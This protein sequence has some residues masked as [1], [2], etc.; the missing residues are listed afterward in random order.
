[1]KNTMKAVVLEST[2][3][4]ENFLYKDAPLPELK[5]PQHVLVRVQACGVAYRDIIERRG[6]HPLLRTPIIQGHEFSGEVVSVGS[7][8]KRWKL[9]DRVI[10]RYTDSCGQCDECVGGDERLCIKLTQM[11]GLITDG[12]YAEQVLMHERGLERLHDDIDFAQG[13]C[14]MSAV[15]VAYHNVR[16]RLAVRPGETVLLTGASGGVGLAALQCLKLLGATVWAVTSS[17][18]KVAFLEEM[19]ADRVLVND[20]KTIHKAVRAIQPQG[21][22][23]AVDCV[24]SA[25]LGSVLKSMRRLGR[26]AVVGT[27][28][29]EPLSLNLGT[30]VVNGLTIKG[31][32]GNTRQAIRESMALVAAGKI[33]V[34]IDRALPLSQ[35]AEAHRMLENREAVGRILLLPQANNEEAR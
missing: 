10:N 22:D 24:G 34:H 21:I 15:A 27:I 33:R 20:G 26:V 29:P 7:S 19:G 16:N 11:Y 1:M 18:D 8:V 30:L 6:G 2:G 4:A 25:T 5:D 35:A 14:I 23:C 32:D 13:A 31:S 9:G 3:G 12:G 28:S 17:E